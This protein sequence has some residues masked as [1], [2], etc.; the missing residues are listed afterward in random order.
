MNGP[1]VGRAET[2]SQPPVHEVVATE[3]AP[4]AVGPY[5]QAIRAGDF[6]FTAGQLGIDPTTKKLVEG[7]VEAQAGQALTNLQAI[8]DAAGSGLDQVAKVTV[9]VADINDFA[10]V[11]A[12]Y[13]QF[14]TQNPPARSAAQVAALP[15][16]GLV[17]IE[18]I[19]LR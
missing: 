9:F 3:N 14:F 19:A 13:A 16:G 17:M 2:L 5:S 11:N 4:P 18:A 10:A 6:I 15:L 7:G 8:L 1:K 12:V